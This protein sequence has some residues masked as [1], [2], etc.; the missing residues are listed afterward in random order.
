MKRILIILLLLNSVAYGQLCTDTDTVRSVASSLIT[1]NSARTNGTVA[2]FSPAVT[3][4]QMKYVRVGFTDTV[5]TTSGATVALRNLSS[6]QAATQYVYY[7]KAVCATGGPYPSAYYYFTTLQSTVT[8]TPM[9]A[10]GYQYKYLKVDSGFSLTPGDTSLGRA[11]ATL[12]MIKYKSSDNTYYG[13]YVDCTCW[14]ALAIDSSGI[15]ALLNN[16]VDSVTVSGDSLW[17]WK[18]GVSYGYILPTQAN[19][20]VV[21]VDDVLGNDGTGVLGSASLPY[22]TLSAAKTAA[23]AGYTVVVRPGTYAITTT[24][25]KNGV[26]WYFYP[27][28]VV[29]L[30]ND[31][32]SVGIWDDGGAAMTFTVSGAGKFIRTTADD[33]LAAKNIHVTH[34]SSNISIEA[35]ELTTNAGDDGTGSSVVYQTA[36]VVNVSSRL[37]TSTGASG[38]AVWWINGSMF[39][40][41]S[42]IN[43]EYT[44]VFSEVNAAPA[45]DCNI[46]AYEIITNALAIAV[47]S[48]GTNTTAAIWLHADIIKGK[49]SSSPLSGN[50][51]Y[52]N[53]QKIFGVVDVLGPG[54]FYITTDKITDMGDGLVNL[55]LSAGTVRINVD[56]LDPSTNTGAITITG[57]ELQLNNGDYIGTATSIGVSITGG[58]ALLTDCNFNTAANSG[59]SPITKSGGTLTLRNNIL[60]AQAAANG[61]SAPTSQTVISY[62]SVSNRP[63]DSDVVLSGD[64]TVNSLSYNTNIASGVGTK[65]LRY[66]PATDQIT[67]ADT[68]AGGGGSPSLTATYIG[69]GDGSNLLTGTNKFTFDAATGIQNIS[70]N[71][72]AAIN[73]VPTPSGGGASALRF[74][75]D[76]GFFSYMTVGAASY[77]FDFSLAGY[78][79]ATIFHLDQSSNY[80]ATGSNLYIGDVTTTPTAYLHLKAGTASASTAGIKQTTGTLNTTAEA[81]TMEYNNA[82][83]QTNNALNRVASG[84]AIKDFITTVD[85]GTT[86]ETDLF[87]YTTKASTLAA[88]GEKISFKIAGTFND[89]TAT[90]QLQ[91]Y[92]GGT[93]IGNTG[94]LTVSAIGGWN[95]D[96]MVIR[97]GASTA[98]S[99]VTVNTPGASTAIY[100][101]QT[102]ITGLTFTNTQ[103]IKIT[104][105]AAGASGGTGDISAKLGTIFWNGAANN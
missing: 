105:T 34:A 95:A 26:N 27:G 93:N 48:S 30:T 89:L 83:Y 94:A 3:G 38:Y 97:T 16:K 8:Y 80:V 77:D 74:Y 84:G 36:G 91:F 102:D 47:T 62:G 49:V 12:G 1:Y 42:Q 45:G 87:T 15:I 99:V 60:T 6:L 50:K 5:T 100:T 58:I 13:Y 28:A 86:V 32:D 63:M 46:E 20:N 37:I 10:M 14:R 53:S 35:D 66:D 78:A 88:D 2:H 103:I 76:G 71:T 69:Y 18:Q 52:I 96:I 4:L 101:T 65:S 25:A 39:I 90:A 17:Y 7:Y 40:R 85:N 55:G 9:T 22:L 64:M 79:G 29:T 19:G 68:T 82:H 11:P 67:Y 98:R 43:S 92:Y 57:G 61:I 51:V 24:I 23:T 81:G 104:G 59:T 44:C 75:G 21:W 56:H 73:L 33:F 70:G 54:L 72:N 31:I 41:A